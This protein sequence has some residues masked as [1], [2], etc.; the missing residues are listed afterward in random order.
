MI[1][2]TKIAIPNKLKR[3]I[4]FCSLIILL[5][6]W[7]ISEIRAQ[8]P[9]IT[10]FTGSTPRGLEPGAP[11]GS[12]PL[13][14]FEQVNLFNGSLHFN[15]PL[16]KVGG[17]GTYHTIARSIEQ[18]W[19]AVR[20]LDTCES[21]VCGGEPKFYAADYYDDWWTD[22]KW[23][24]GMPSVIF[25]AVGV[26]GPAWCPGFR[27][28]Q[29]ITR[30]TLIMPDGTE[31]EMRDLLTGGGPLRPPDCADRGG[32]RGR[33]WVTTD[34]ISA[35]FIT[36]TDTHDEIILESSKGGAGSGDLYLRDGTRYHF[37]AGGVNWMQDRNG[38]RITFYEGPAWTTDGRETQATTRIVDPLGREVNISYA[39]Y[40]TVFEDRISYYGFGRAPRAIRIGYA[41]LDQVI[42]PDYSIKT[43]KQLFPELYR[44]ISCCFGPYTPFRV[45]FVEM[46]DGR[47]YRFFYNDYGELARVELPTGGA[48]EYDWTPGTGVVDGF[49]DLPKIHRRVTK[50]RVYPNGGAGGA[51]EREEVFT[52]SEGPTTMVQVDRYK[53]GNV[54]VTRDKHYFHGNIVDSLNHH[55]FTYTHWRMGREFKTE[56]FAANGATLLRRV[57]SIWQQR[58]PVSWWPCDIPDCGPQNDPRVTEVV[59]TLV[60]TNQVSRQAFGYDQY[61]NNTDL[62]E[63]DFGIGAPGP[64]MRRTR[65]VYL[66]NNGYQNNVNYAEDLNIH[67][68]NLPREVHLLDG[69]GK[70]VSLTY[71]DYD[72]Y[73]PY[74]LQDCPGIVQHDGAFN[75]SYGKRGNLTLVTKFASIIPG[76]GPADPIYLHNQYDIAGNIVKMV[77]PRGF[78]TNISFNDNF[79]GPDNDARS[80][81]G[82]PEL[83]GGGAYAFPTKV[84]NALDHTTY[85]QYDYYLGK[86]VNSE[87]ANGFISS[88]AYDDAL[89][90]PTQ[91]IQARYKASGG[92]PVERRQTT[93]TY[94]DAR[95]VIMMTSDRNTFED[96]ILTKKAYYDGL[97]RTWRSASHEGDTWVIGD[98]QFDALGGIS[99]V[100]NPYRAVNPDSA[101]P[102]PGLW[103]KTVYDSLGRVADVETPDGAHV[104]T[105]YR[106]SQVTAIDQ[107]G[108]TRLSETDALG[109][110]VRVIEAPDD[111]RYVTTYLYD[112]MNNLRFVNQGG[113]G[114]WF[115]YDALSRMIRARVPEQDCNPN[116]PSHTDPF[117]GGNCWSMAHKYDENGNL[118]E[119]MDA[120]G[121]KTTIT[122]DKLNRATSKVYAGTTQEGTEVANA[123]PRVNWFY[124]DYSALASLSG[125]PSWPGT[126]S[127]GRLIGA[128]YGG[129]SEGTYHKYDPLG[130]IVTNHQR[131]GTANYVTNYTYNR[132]DAVTVESRMAGSQA[133][134]RNVMSYDEA[135]RL[136]AMDASVFSGNGS[137]FSRLVGDISYTSSGALQSEIYGN[138]LI[139]SMAYNN[140][141]QL[142][143]MSLGTPD[144]LESV[145]RLNYIYGTANNVNAQDPE[146]AAIANNGNIARIK[147]FINGSLQYSQTSQ[148]D[149]VNRLS[150]AVEHNNGLYNDASRAWYQTFAYGPHG[151]RGTDVDKTSDNADGMNSALK[152]D[153]FS[154]AN[155]RIMRL[156]FVYDANGNLT[157]EPE[158]KYFYNAENKLYKAIVAGVV[159]SENFYDANGHRVRKVVDGV[160]TRFVYGKDG[161][162][163]E[164]RNDSTSVV[165]KDYF[166]RDGELLATTKEGG[167]YEYATADHLGSPRAWTSG[168]DGNLTGLSRHDYMPF[169]E[170]LF[171]GYGVR[172]ADQGYA[173]MSQQD[174]QRKQFAGYERENETGLDFAEARYHSNMQGRFTSVDPVIFAPHRLSDPQSLN[175]YSYVRN[176]PLT[177]VD[178]T[179]MDWYV[180]AKGVY[181]WFEDDPGAG[182]KR[183]A[184]GPNGH[185]I[186]NVQG[187][188]GQYA[189]YNGHN[190]TLYND[191]N[192]YIVDEGVYLPVISNRLPDV[193]ALTNQLALDIVLT[194]YGKPLLNAVT[195]GGATVGGVLLGVGG[196]VVDL[197]A[198]E[199]AG[200]ATAATVQANKAAGDAFRDEV[201]EE[202]KRAGKHVEIEQT[203]DTPFGSR[204][205]DIHVYDKPGGTLEGAVETKVG[206]SRYHASQ[207]SKDAYLRMFRK[208]ITHVIRKK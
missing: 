2:Y 56:T 66:T 182:W 175:L 123:T 186:T 109:R 152:L 9:D 22:I 7:P 193:S 34:G 135:G 125:A 173:A 42:R 54:L 49:S 3:S 53:P 116:L 13:S 65:T 10:P 100:S 168:K 196:E 86:A 132:G 146:I 1:T 200:T 201:A 177:L 156:G 155:N 29:T 20:R 58:D 40:T 91:G 150:Y 122:Y 165:T 129:G 157:D 26:P 184:I 44:N 104:I 77:D 119:K 93:F 21:E 197:F 141:L 23:S 199:P 98:T 208:I 128:T 82:A 63:Y 64:L 151:N 138:G 112:P 120:R 164:E 110:L 191:P 169:G 142:T 118:T 96:N 107:G 69:N 163:I 8:N 159:T 68:R 136:L 154:S 145:F 99:Q 143:E 137:D 11:A 203:V 153:E 121:V 92:V 105:Q 189:R 113:Q 70:L 79:G 206:G 85:T 37:E 6:G 103:T 27:N 17:R 14:G 124:D 19:Y 192:R 57:E 183:A 87:D 185:K 30:A 51:F 80:N 33:V 130:R 117:T 172:T 12:F 181:Y 47:R 61:N 59:T 5:L 81:A 202:L 38:N 76:S 36:A 194:F 158:K 188:T 204:R 43:H 60:D 90:R 171:A 205:H 67:I 162:L 74:P 106:G 41:R 25:R 190:V 73:N 149:G 55:P 32:N 166:Y 46:P 88:I 147:Y 95:R 187:A 52:F 167:G 39:N 180:D 131:Q 160:A 133:R 83:N 178:P 94:D 161:E 71:L 48:Y 28:I 4:Q 170:E 35:T 78:P 16:L 134:R 115:A 102:P 84:T 126:P 45:A 127:K 111:L 195:G 176:N 198:E 75:T 179:G 50:R 139:H 18:H 15:L 101:S 114:R 24:Y 148:Y 207:R 97:G 140:R 89:D 144:N 72:R 62:L 108:K 174:G 31:H